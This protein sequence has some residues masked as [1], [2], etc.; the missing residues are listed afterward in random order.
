MNIFFI[1]FF[2]AQSPTNAAN[3]TI[4]SPGGST[5]TTTTT[6]SGAF[7]WTNSTRANFKLSSHIIFAFLD[8][9]KNIFVDDV[10]EFVQGC[11][12]DAGGQLEFGP[13]TVGPNKGPLGCGSHGSRTTSWTFYGRI[14]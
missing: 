11:K 3:T 8:K 10:F 1:F 4:K 7:V 12:F 5:T 14:G 13:S 2:T 9:F 6:A